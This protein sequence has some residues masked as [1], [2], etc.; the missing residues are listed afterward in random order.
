[1]AL[2][3]DT[4][5]ISHYMPLDL[6]WDGRKG[7]PTRDRMVNTVIQKVKDMECL[8]RGA[9]SQATRE[10]EDAE[11]RSVIDILKGFGDFV[12]ALLTV[13][14]FV[15]QFNLCAR[16]DCVSK[17]RMKQYKRH[18]VYDFATKMAVKWQK[19]MREERACPPQII[20]G[21]MDPYYC[22]QVNMSVYL[23]ENIRRGGGKVGYD[24]A[25]L[26]SE[27]PSNVDKEGQDKTPRRAVRG[28]SV[29]FRGSPSAQPSW[30]SQV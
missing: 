16:G 18:S 9:P 2:E 6:P 11:Y 23:E 25:F 19:V 3:A 17:L 20:F 12:K 14:M 21:A 24:G 15:L 26:F 22:P 30:L 7:N 27:K 1:M 29:S 5:A 8:H 28:T 13:N 10:F 4:H